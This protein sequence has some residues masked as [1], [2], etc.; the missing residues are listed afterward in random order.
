MIKSVFSSALAILVAAIGLGAQTARL[1]ADIPFSF[2]VGDTV[3]PAGSYDVET[4]GG[5]IRMR[6]A[7]GEHKGVMTLANR[8]ESLN[9]KPASLVFSRYGDD[10]FLSGVWGPAAKAGLRMAPGRLEKELAS[11]ARFASATEIAAKSPR[12]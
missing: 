11:R 2:R 12:R 3:M 6:T 10:Y 5:V 9:P 8:E 7:K 4:S 1:N